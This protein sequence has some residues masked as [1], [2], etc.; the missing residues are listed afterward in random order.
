[1]GE[2]YEVLIIKSIAMRTKI[3]FSMLFSCFFFMSCSSDDDLPENDDNPL[4]SQL[5]GTWLLE[6]LSA[7]D[8]Y[9]DWPQEM[10][11]IHYEFRPGGVLVLTWDEDSEFGTYSLNGDKLTI[12][13][14]D[15]PDTYTI[16]KLNSA[17]LQL[18]ILEDVDDQPG[19][20]EV[21]IYFSRV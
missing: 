17:E 14:G 9:E 5:R 11:V 10:G 4:L 15:A 20:E 7:D 3:L 19:D 21:S 12:E 16:R 18:F 2:D 8:V 13:A 1:M 6:G